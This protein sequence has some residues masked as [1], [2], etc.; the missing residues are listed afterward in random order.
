MTTVSREELIV[1]L[2]KFIGKSCSG[3]LA[4]GAAGSLVTLE[5]EPRVYDRSRGTLSSATI[6]DRLSGHSGARPRPG[7]GG[8]SGSRPAG[9]RAGFPDPPQASRW[10][11]D[12]SRPGGRRSRS[13]RSAAK[14]QCPRSPSL[15]SGCR[16]TKAF[17]KG[18]VAT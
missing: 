16:S 12:T 9:L 2:S 7:A 17:T 18:Q 11:P 5:F 15:Y 6:Q 10:S 1:A 3:Y 8:G 13:A 4:G 14:G